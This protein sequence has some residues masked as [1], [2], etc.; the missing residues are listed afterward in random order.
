MTTDDAGDRHA[1]NTEEKGCTVLI[2][3]FFF[4][5]YFFSD[6]DRIDRSIWVFF[7]TRLHFFSHDS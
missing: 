6:K 2:A 5:F 1:D 3:K 7:F 4:F